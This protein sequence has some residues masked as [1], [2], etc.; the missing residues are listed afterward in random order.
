MEL[1][2]ILTGNATY[3]K[4]QKQFDFFQLLNLLVCQMNDLPHVNTAANDQR[5]GETEEVKWTP[6]PLI[7]NVFLFLI[8][9]N[10]DFR[11]KYSNTRQNVAKP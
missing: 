6:T 2:V 10:G 8:K 11:M 7:M 9:L 1:F 3:P 4:Y 5:L